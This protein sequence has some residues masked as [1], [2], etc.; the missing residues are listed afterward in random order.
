MNSSDNFL[1]NKRTSEFPY[2][3]NRKEK[4]EEIYKQKLKDKKKKKKKDK[5]ANKT[6]ENNDKE[7]LLKLL[8][9]ESKKNKNNNLKLEYQ[10]IEETPKYKNDEVNS[11]FEKVFNLFEKKIENQNK[12]I[13]S[14]TKEKQ[15]N[16][17][18]EKI[19]KEVK[20]NPDDTSSDEDELLIPEESR[21]KRKKILKEQGQSLLADL[22]SKAQYPEVVE[23]WDTNANDPELLIH[24][25]CMPNTV[26]VPIHWAQNGKYLQSQRGKVRK[27]YKL[28]DYIE[29]TG[30][31]RIRLI[32]LPVH[33]SLQQKTRR[34]M[35]PKLGRTDIDYQI[36]YDAFF[37]YQ[38]KKRLTKLGEVYYEG[39]ETDKRMSKFKPGKLSRNL[40]NAL[41]I[42]ASTIPPFVQNMQ[43]Y[44]PPPAYPFLKIPGVNIP[45]DDASA[46]AT[47]GLW[48]E[49]DFRYTKEF[50][51]NFDT[52]KSHWYHYN[53]DDMIEEEN[54]NDDEEKDLDDMGNDQDDLEISDEE[55][56]DISGLFI[57]Q[58]DK[59]LIDEGI[60][61]DK[62]EDNINKETKMEEDKIMDE[63]EK[64]ENVN[65]NKES[66]KFYKI[67][68]QEKVD[69]KNN[70][71]N[72]V[73]Y[74]YIMYNI[75]GINENKID[76]KVENN[77]K[78]ENKE[79]EEE[80]EEEDEQDIENINKNI[81]D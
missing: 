64:N 55:K 40:R 4:N 77:Q 67:I 48:D 58:D 30:I 16:I 37:K 14:L 76:N 38:T 43:R 11:E 54:E 19:K 56:P 29:A 36:L 26:P 20:E 57:K 52:D 78:K 51:W 81:F 74:K 28:P 32:E 25:K 18:K 27:P 33:I 24:F 39:K 71:L 8:N 42:S 70:E 17:P 59:Q 23:P 41:G 46:M 9:D 50:I 31:S 79:E 53:K 3:L 2:E 75:S 22:K 15:P 72:P 1:G 66:E 7:Y 6:K 73:G 49:P 5:K 35:R 68:E 34:R 47:P 60:K 61:N 13:E 80:E 10:P 21:K 45:D 12:K 62:I 44:G 65:E 69:L 63:K